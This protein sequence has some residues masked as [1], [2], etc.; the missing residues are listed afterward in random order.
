MHVVFPVCRNYGISFILPSIK[1]IIFLDGGAEMNKSR[2]VCALIC[3]FLILFTGCSRLDEIDRS[4]DEKPIYNDEDEESISSQADPDDEQGTKGSGKKQNDSDPEARNH[5][6]ALAE[7]YIEEYYK[8]LPSEEKSI[9]ELVKSGKGIAIDG[10][11]DASNV[12]AAAVFLSATASSQYLPVILSAGAVIDSPE[13]EVI[14]NNFG[15]MVQRLNQTED[16]L[17]IL[18]YANSLESESPMILTNLGNAYLDD[19]KTDKAEECYH[20]ALELDPDFGPAHEGMVYVHLMRADGQKAIEE[21]VEAARRGYSPMLRAAYKAAKKAGGVIDIPPWDKLLDNDPGSSDNEN[22]EENHTQND[23]LILPDLPKWESRGAFIATLPNLSKLIEDSMQ[24]GMLDAIVFAVTYH[25]EDLEEA[26]GEEGFGD[27]ED[28]D[29]Y[30]EDE[31]D[32]DMDDI[33]SIELM[34]SYGQKLFMLEL[35]NDY[36]AEKINQAYN[37]TLSKRIQIDDAYQKDIDSIKES[38]KFKSM[39]KKIMENDIGGA[40]ALGKEINKMSAQMA[41]THFYAWRDITLQNYNEIKDLLY[42]YWKISDQVTGSIYDQDVVDYINKIR[43][44]T[45]YASILPITTDFSMLPT[46]YALADHIAPIVEPDEDLSQYK[47]EPIGTVQTPPIK[48]KEC[49]I[50][51]KK[52]SVTM[53]PASFAVT[54]DTWEFEFLEGIGGAIK[55]NFKTGE[56]EITVL[57]GVKTG[58]GT[59]EFSGK[60]GVTMKFDSDGNFTGWRTTTNAGAKVGMGPIEVSGNVGF[61]GDVG[62]IGSPNAGVSIGTHGGAAGIGTE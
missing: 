54:C 37:R 8:L 23:M 17:A 58:A 1:G 61:S 35:V 62:S 30:Y 6:V 47:P 16:S 59:T 41:D 3:A 22:E 26:F 4:T 53:G 15:T 10:L 11:K 7:K 52:L 21:I 19:G 56:T 18:L 32:A 46:T 33:A 24:K 50:K 28:Y 40:K 5:I 38:A 42:E 25:P 2:R 45:V 43:E 44:I 34:P 29:G 48:K 36:F 12:S 57:V 20:K 31:E 51:G 60:T 27:Y 49:A 14:V 39:E 13:D 9:I 55:Q